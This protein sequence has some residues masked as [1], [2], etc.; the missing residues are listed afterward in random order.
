[1]MRHARCTEF[2]VERLKTRSYIHDFTHRVDGSGF[3]F[4]QSQS[5]IFRK[6][7]IKLI[8][9]AR[10][11]QFIQRPAHC[12]GHFGHRAKQ[13]PGTANKEPQLRPSLNG[14]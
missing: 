14:A 11:N 4:N 6:E 1:M 10:S 13:L 8:L 3:T 12:K 5:F 7:V 2:L 9:G